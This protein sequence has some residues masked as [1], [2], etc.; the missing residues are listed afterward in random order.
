LEIVERLRFLERNGRTM[1]QA[2]LQ[3]VLAHPAVS[4][5]IPGAKNPQQAESNAKSADGE[6]TSDE[7]AA[8][9]A[10]VPPESVVG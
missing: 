9:N 2:A 1:A 4:C 7:L 6:L 5:A 8:I 3:F 10:I